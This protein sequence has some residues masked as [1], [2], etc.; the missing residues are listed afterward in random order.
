M[1]AF[2]RGLD[3]EFVEALN[4]E[5][6]REDGWWSQFVD[7]KELFLAIRHN[8]VHIYYQGCRLIEVAW[9]NGEI[10]ANTHYKYLLLSNIE[11]EYVDVVVDGKPSV[12]DASPYFADGLSATDLKQSAE[13]YVGDEK[14]GVHE[15]LRKNP[16]ILD[17]EIAISD[18]EKAPRIDFAALQQDEAGQTHIV[19]YEAKHF[20]NRGA[21]RRSEGPA[22]VIEQ[23]S[24]YRKLLEDY[25][26]DIRKSYCRVSENL[27]ALEGVCRPERH[28]LDRSDDFVI[29]TEPGLVVFGFDQD[30][31]TGSVWKRHEEKLE[32]D[33]HGGLILR[34]KPEDVEVPKQFPR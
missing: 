16:H 27:L 22:S 26:P 11:P 5:Y 9:R 15:I 28:L 4:K 18:G 2:N 34:G 30:Q 20:D 14:K 6:D 31:R 10:V 8:Q 33:V 19:F 25:G 32:A 29:E 1:A 17:V 7:D 24:E 12:P 21:L 23:I 3:D 13:P